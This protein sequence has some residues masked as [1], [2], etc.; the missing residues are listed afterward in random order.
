LTTSLPE[1]LEKHLRAYTLTAAAAGVGVLALAPPAQAD[2]IFGSPSP[3]LPADVVFT[4][5]SLNYTN[6]IKT[7]ISGRTFNRYSMAIDLD[8]NGIPDLVFS[9]FRTY[10]IIGEIGNMY[11]RGNL[12]VLPPIAGQEV[13]PG[14]PRNQQFLMAHFFSSFYDQSRN[15][16]SGG[17]PN[18]PGFVG[19]QF[20]IDGQT[21]FGWVGFDAL[22]SYCC[23]DLHVWG[24]AYDTVP[25]EPI[26][27]FTSKTSEP[28]SASLALLALGALGLAAW[29]RR[30]VATSEN[31]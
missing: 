6:F 2:A 1:K 15:Y 21:H 10:N 3:N 17:F 22:T 30:K 27:T 7:H 23:A 4:P 29:R 16:I 14:G 25:N 26:Q 28:T 20:Q 12:E 9:G 18:G 11:V 31:V 24:Y 13:G 8:H 19:V 5:A